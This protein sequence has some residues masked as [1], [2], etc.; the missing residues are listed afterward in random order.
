MSIIPADLV[1]R[2]TLPHIVKELSVAPE[3]QKSIQKFMTIC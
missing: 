1:S 2:M 3:Q